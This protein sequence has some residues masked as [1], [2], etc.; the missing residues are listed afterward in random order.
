MNRRKPMEKTRVEKNIYKD[1]Q[2]NLYYVSLYY[3]RDENGNK[4]HKQ[5]TATSLREA[6]KSETNTPRRKLQKN[7]LCQSMTHWSST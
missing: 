4:V 6:K 5:K 7:W 1:D 3:G 2:R